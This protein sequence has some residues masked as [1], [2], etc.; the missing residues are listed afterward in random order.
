[1]KSR[2]ANVAALERSQRIDDDRSSS[3]RCATARDAPARHRAPIDHEQARARGKPEPTAASGGIVA[4]DAPAATLENMSGGSNP[5]GRLDLSD[6]D[7]LTPH[8]TVS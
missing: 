4:K 6:S 3:G 5:L 8:E 7:E 2:R 1:V